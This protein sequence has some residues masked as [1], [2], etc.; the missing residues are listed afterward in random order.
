LRE[1][2]S[3][4]EEVGNYKQDNLVQKLIGEKYEA[5]NAMEDVLSLQKI[6]TM[7]LKAFC[8]SEDIFDLH[9]YECKESLDP[10]VKEKIISSSTQK[11]IV[12][13]S[14]SLPKL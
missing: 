4:K 7:K 3:H 1:I 8:K 13:L 6:F 12:G 14:L 2:A 9:Y 5:H 10:L 11:K